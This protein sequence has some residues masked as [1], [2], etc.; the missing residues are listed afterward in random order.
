MGRR[1]KEVTLTD[2]RDKGRAFLL[3]EMAADQGERLALRALLAISR[4]GVNVPPQ[5]FDSGWAGLAAMMPYLFV[6]GFQGLAGARW[7]ELEPLLAEMMACVQYAPG[8]GHPP[9][10]IKT[11]DLCQIEEVKSFLKLRKMVLE[12]HLDPSE[13]A[14][15]Q[16]M[17]VPAPLPGSSA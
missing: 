16:T 13:A 7:E 4:S 9:Q 14:A 5:L 10:A 12:L 3:T 6:I 1:T 15:L 2:G 11:G 17:G 8:H